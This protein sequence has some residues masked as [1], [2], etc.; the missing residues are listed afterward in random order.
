MV[1]PLVS[2]GE[3]STTEL[4][5]PGHHHA[6]RAAAAG[7]RVHQ[8]RVL[9]ITARVFTKVE[10]RDMVENVRGLRSPWQCSLKE[11][12]Y[13]RSNSLLNCISILYCRANVLQALKV[14][15]IPVYCVVYI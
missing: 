15:S 13:Y 6:A 12:E 8:T 14:Y 5:R 11:L 1:G 4:A 2:G 9:G 7:R 3:E 10:G